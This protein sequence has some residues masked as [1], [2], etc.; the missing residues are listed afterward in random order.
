[1]NKLIEKLRA[2]NNVFKSSLEMKSFFDIKQ[3]LEKL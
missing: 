3:F 1:M 2:I